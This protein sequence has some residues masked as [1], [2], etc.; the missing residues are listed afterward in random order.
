MQREALNP[1]TLFS[2]RQYGFSQIVSVQ[3]GRT[4]YFSG[5][6]AWDEN[7]QIVGQDNLKQQV[8]Q[9]LKNV[10]IAVQAAGGTLQ[11]IVS[12]RIYIVADKLKNSSAVSEGLHAFFPGGNP[13]TA[14]W[15][16]VRALANKSFLIEIEPIAVI[17]E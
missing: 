10:E 16:G 14:T 17:G 6:V 1:D 9:S 15:I 13:P 5:Q 11:D 3:G 4:V 12:M 8:W 2:S 7:Q